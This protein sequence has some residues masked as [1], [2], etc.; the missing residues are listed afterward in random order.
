MKIACVFRWNPYVYTP[1]FTLSMEN[2]KITIDWLDKLNTTIQGD[3]HDTSSFSMEEILNSDFMSKYTKFSSLE[4]FFAASWFA[5][6]END[7]LQKYANA[8]FD[9]FITKNTHF[10]CWNEMVSCAW[11]EFLKSRTIDV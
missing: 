6:V 3:T 7:N 11:K 5:V 1:R 8:D 4:E 9:Y 10:T 2:M